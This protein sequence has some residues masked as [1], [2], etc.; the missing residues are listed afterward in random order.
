MNHS[1][2]YYVVRGI[3]RAVVRIGMAFAILYS[4]YWF[5]LLF[6]ATFCP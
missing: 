2:T 4:A 3:A 5:I 1:K 6:W